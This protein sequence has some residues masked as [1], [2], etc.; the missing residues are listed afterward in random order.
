MT[1]WEYYSKRRNINLADFISK[2]S[3]SY[4]DLCE[5]CGGRKVEPPS[6]ELYQGSLPKPKAKTK[7]QP[8]KKVAQ[9]PQKP[10]KPKRK[11]TRKNNKSK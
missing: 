5:F 9:P 6:K 8:V 1:T 2:N 7:K 4:E 11:Y 3:M 10:A